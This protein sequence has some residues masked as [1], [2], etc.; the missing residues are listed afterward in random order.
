LGLLL[1]S[2]QRHPWVV[3]VHLLLEEPLARRPQWDPLRRLQE[4]V[5]LEALMVGAAGCLVVGVVVASVP[6]LLLVAG[7]LEGSRLS[8]LLLARRAR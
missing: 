8:P 6:P 7:C 4:A 2:V 3:G 5:S 1:L